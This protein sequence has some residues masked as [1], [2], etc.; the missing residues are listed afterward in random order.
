MPW[1]N[2]QTYEP[3]E[4]RALHWFLWWNQAQHKA[5]DDEDFSIPLPTSAQTAQWLEH[6]ERILG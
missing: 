6:I 1:L 5:G 3:S 4:D 2:Q